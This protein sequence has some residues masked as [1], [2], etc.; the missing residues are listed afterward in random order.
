MAVR[1]PLPEE[2]RIGTLI[3][4][5]YDRMP[6]PEPGRIAQIAERLAGRQPVVRVRSGLNRLPWW[7]VLLAVGGAAAAAWYAGEVWRHGQ[8]PVAESPERDGQV[9]QQDIRPPAGTPRDPA[10]AQVP[11]PETAPIQEA[12]PEIIYRR[13]RE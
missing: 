2:G 3:A 8:I 12:R 4:Q 9:R 5:A 10:K 7:I 13:E 1:F 11:P 6:G